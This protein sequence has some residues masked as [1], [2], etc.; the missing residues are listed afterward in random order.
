MLEEIVARTRED[1]ARR[2]R[3]RPLAAWRATVTPS[4]RGFAAALRARR[5][6]FVMEC[7]HA[8]PSE[9]TLRDAY[10]PAEIAAAYAPYAD[11]ISVL[12]DGPFFRGSHEH[13][14]AV[15]AAVDLP[16][17]CKDFV[18]D[19]Y[20]VY[21]AREAGADA[22]LLM[23][24]V[25]D[26][27]EYAACA[28]AAAAAGIET[29]TEAHSD[30]E[31]DRAYALGAPIIGVNNR[32]L[33]TLRVN[34]DTTRR[35]A[36]RVP[37]DRLVICESGIRTHA[38]V[39]ELG[40]LVDGFLVGT[41]LMRADDVPQAV[42]ALVFGMTKVCGLTRPDDARAAWAAGA[43]HGGLIFASD[44]KRAVDESTAARVQRAAPLRWVGVLVNDS[45]H[46]VAALAGRLRLDAVQLHGDETAEDIAILRPLLPP[47]CEVWKALR[48]R[49]EIPVADKTGAD[50]VLLDRW[51][52]T[53]AGGTGKRFD[54]SLLADRADRSRMILSGGLTPETVAAAE[55]L[56]VV[57]LDVSSGVEDSPGIKSSARLAAFFAER[58]GA[59]REH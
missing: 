54:W 8:S 41:A 19:P 6:G 55:A 37:A 15:R 13:L 51:H 40:P 17:L 5:T 38:E 16:L 43:T 24:S 3:G 50:R 10:R 2:A 28:R 11:A 59:G 46:R 7:K 36:P 52:P 53:A 18:V 48:V 49:D 44:S 30:V 58:R 35:L 9:G 39:R 29:L 27:D 33:A 57:G 12:T 23:L 22:V 31:L 42:R 26:D 21:E 34:L 4:R 32:D 1:V 14:R 20:Q 25:L 56:G 47:G 45:L